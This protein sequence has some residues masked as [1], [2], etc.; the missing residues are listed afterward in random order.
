MGL[1]VDADIDPSVDLYG[2][3]VSNLQSNINVS[4]DSIT[5]NLKF[6]EDYVD[7]PGSDYETGYFIALHA[8]VPDVEDVQITV[9]VEDSDSET[10]GENG[11]VVKRIEDKN[12]QTITVVAS[13]TGYESVTKEYDLSGLVLLD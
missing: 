2:K 3:V 8:E 4:D 1:S 12:L 10:L 9:K 5:G 6:I 7:F 11:I 13:K